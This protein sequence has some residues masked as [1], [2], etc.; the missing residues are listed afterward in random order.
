MTEKLK[1]LGL[2]TEAVRNTALNPI[3]FRRGRG[4]II[5][6]RALSGKHA[7]V[8]LSGMACLTIRQEN[9]DRQIWAFNYP[10]DFLALLGFQH[11]YSTQYVEVEALSDCSIGTID[12]EKLEWAIQHDPALGQAL[13]HAAMIEASVVRQRLVM[14]RLP[15]LR[16]VAHLLCEHLCRCGLVNPVVPLSQIDVA[17]AVGLSVVQAKRIFEELHRLGV[18]AKR[19]PIEVVNPERLQEL[20]AFDGRYL[21]LDETLSQW[22]LRIEG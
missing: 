4:E 14:A 18:L 20:A 5:T 7:T 11:P 8:L 13:W 9:G 12:C 3:E 22:D 15:A 21:D 17:D 16:R 2:D 10:G 19:W 1:G 6:S